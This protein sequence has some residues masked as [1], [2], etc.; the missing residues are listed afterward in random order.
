MV[1]ISPPDRPHGTPYSDIKIH[2]IEEKKVEKEEK[3]LPKNKDLQKKAVAYTFLQKFKKLFEKGARHHHP[4]PQPV[5]SS[6]I[7]DLISDIHAFL[8]AL[9]NKEVKEDVDS[10]SHFSG[11]WNL[12]RKELEE[13]GQNRPIDKTLLEFMQEVENYSRN[14]SHN[15]GHYLFAYAGS[16]WL[17]F[18]FLDLLKELH[19]SF[20]K[21]PVNCLLTKWQ[22]TLERIL[23]DLRKDEIRQP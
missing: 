10:I 6:D 11:N 2:R 7:I 23:Q 14:E 4:Q 19:Y 1:D 20:K 17:P 5:Y 21:D 22:K 9:Q 16:E 18:P 15:L 12:L 13:Q 8:T 3:S